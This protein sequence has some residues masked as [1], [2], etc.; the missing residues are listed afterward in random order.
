MK[1]LVTL[2]LVFLFTL[3]A[4]CSCKLF[5]KDKGGDT[6]NADNGNTST[7]SSDYFYAPGVELSVLLASDSEAIM[8]DLFSIVFEKLGVV[9]VLRAQSSA[10]MKHEIIFGKSNREVSVRAYQLLDRLVEMEGMAGYLI[11]SDGTSV[12]VA[13]STTDVL[14]LAYEEFVKLCLTPKDG[15]VELKSGTLTGNAFDLY[16]YFDKCDEELRATQWAK[17]TDYIN[18]LGYDGEGTVAAFKQ[19]YSLYSDGAYLWLANL[20]DPIT[21]GFYYSN[22][23]RETVKFAP[24]LESTRQALDLLRYSGMTSDLKGTLPEEMKTNLVAWVQSLQRSN[25]YFYHP[26]WD[27]Y[28]TTDE[29]LGRDVTNARSLLS[30]FGAKPNYTAYTPSDGIVATSALASP[31]STSKAIAVSQVIPTASGHLASEEAFL[32]YLNSQNW[33]DSYTSGNRIAAQFTLIREAGLGDVCLDFMDSIQNPETGMWSPDRDDNAVNG[34]LKISAMYADAGRI[35]NYSSEAADTCIAVLRSEAEPSTVCWVY[36]VWYSLGNIIGLLN[37]KKATA[38]DKALAADIRDRLCKNAAEY[39]TIAYEKYA[40]F[41]KDD[42]SFSFT[43]N[44]SSER[45]QGMPVCVSR[46]NEG[47]V[48]ATYISIISV[49]GRIFAALGY[50]D[51]E[52][53]VYTPNDYKKF[54]NVLEGLGEVEKTNTE[55]GG[56]LAFNGETLEGLFYGTSAVELDVNENQVDEENRAYAY[57]AEEKGERFLTFGKVEETYFND[58][59]HEPRLEFRTIDGGGTRYVY[60]AD[61]CFEKGTAPSNSWH[62]RFAMYGGSGRF[63]YMLCYTTADGKLALDGLNDPLA[64]LEPG[65]W[66]NIRFEYYTDSAV[67][68]N[69]KICMVYIDG[70][71]IGDGGTSGAAGKDT[72]LVRSFIEYRAQSENVEWK[73][74]NVNTTTDDVSYITP[75]P[76]DFGDATGKYYTDPTVKKTRYDYDAEDA[77]VPILVNNNGSAYTAINDGALVFGKT[78]VSGEDAILFKNALS[79]SFWKLTNKTSI[80]EFDL[81]Y[82]SITA[83]TPMK[84]RFGKDIVVSKSGDSLTLSYTYKGTTT[85]VPLDTKSGEWNTLRLEQYWYKQNDA[86]ETY[87]V[88]KVYVNNEYR[89]E[90]LTDYSTATDK[91]YIYLLGKETSASLEIDN[92]LFAHVDKKFVSGDENNAPEIPDSPEEYVPTAEILGVKGGAD[93]IVVIMH[94]DAD[95]ASAKLLDALYEEYGIKGNVAMVVNKMLNADGSPNVAVVNAWKKLINSGRWDITNHSYTHAFWGTENNSQTLEKEIVTSQEILRDLF[96]TRRVLTFAYPGF[97]AKVAELGKDAVYSA[98]QALVSEYYVGARDYEGRT[99]ELSGINWYDI[100]S[101]SIGETWAGSALSDVSMAAGGKMAVIFAHRVVKT[102]AE[103]A[104]DT[105]ATT[106]AKMEEII[107]KISESVESG[108]LW[109]AFFEE[110]ILYLREAEGANVTISGDKDA[111]EVIL[112]DAMADDATYSYPLTVR[113]EVP[114]SWTHAKVVQGGKESYFAAYALGNKWVIDA[115]I[116]PDGGAATLTSIEKYDIPT[117]DESPKELEEYLEEIFDPGDASGDYFKSPDNTGL[118]VDYDSA[119]ATLPDSDAEELLSIKDGYLLFDDGDS[120]SVAKY[121]KYYLGAPSGF[122]TG[123]ESPCSVYEF[124]MNIKQV[125]GTWPIQLKIANNNHTIW[126]DKIDGTNKLTMEAT[127]TYSDGTTEK[128]KIP[129]GITPS[130]WATIRFEHYYN[131]AILKVY[132]NNEYVLEIAT[133]TGSVGSLMI[134]LTSNERGKGSDADL[135]LDNIFIGHFDK[136]YV[137]DG[138]IEKEEIGGGDEGEN[139]GNE[140]EGGETETPVEDARGEYYLSGEAGRRLDYDTITE[141]DASMKTYSGTVGS[142]S[143]VDGSLLIDDGDAESSDVGMKFWLSYSTDFNNAANRCEILEFDFKLTQSYGSYPIQI[144]MAG[145]TYTIYY[146]KAYDASLGTGY[147][148]CMLIDGAYVPLGAKV[149]DWNTVRFEH[150]YDAAMLK[151]YVDNEFVFDIATNAGSTGDSPRITL[152]GNERKTGS[153]ADLYLD[154][155][156]VGHVQK[157]YVAGDPKAD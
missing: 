149:N 58:A 70:K 11:Y 154:N 94:D 36:N 84:W 51:A 3:T 117:Q 26:Q 148:L 79:D 126:F 42:G 123:Y 66:Y 112:T 118:R 92:L 43:K 137:K 115:Q 18:S 40:P 82:S 121:V 72:S 25:G 19:L 22:S 46:M 73:L 74:D 143:I 142:Y 152:T 76:P 24:D 157:D 5:S 146:S 136:A 10:P 23:A 155:I 21:G 6:G 27:N 97:S 86:K 131:E 120:E 47:D 55:W 101:C 105:S 75:P 147:K 48:N 104:E 33:N 93:G 56:A 38:D 12:A 17:L 68:A 45:S 141:I 35:M 156:Y 57:I 133:S 130:S 71:Y 78:E 119:T 30:I 88:I 2:L 13:Y 80:V 49:P 95:L 44:Y 64:V 8:S 127:R 60:E 140:G 54:L 153:N 39:I 87:T 132:V 108:K 111:L 37:S 91:F 90:F 138:I 28:V 67:N 53:D 99:S 85:A 9:P 16:E 77:A 113:I 103:A 106:V 31:L 100:N 122:L 41:R 134:Y 102:D 32:A 125:W 139:G 128:V 114:T 20:Y 7:D 65:K 59:F 1:K 62:T 135:L 150:Y 144:K 83:P 14:D 145:Q 61:V 52:V 63:W 34:F 4:L 15:K 96:T 109:N 151:V 98:A 89:G 69:E 116:I 29:R 81:K 107:S 50:T 124:D 110:A 129:L